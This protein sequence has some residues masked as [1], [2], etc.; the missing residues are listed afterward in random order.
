MVRDAMENLKKEIQLFVTVQNRSFFAKLKTETIR[1]FQKSIPFGRTEGEIEE[2]SLLVSEDP[3]LDTN[4]DE[5][6]RS[7]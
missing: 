6:R 2:T 3:E 5:G 1:F 4:A 7:T